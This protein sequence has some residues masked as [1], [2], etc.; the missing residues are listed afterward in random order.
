MLVSKGVGYGMEM[1]SY[2]SWFLDERP[3]GIWYKH[4]ILQA[5]VSSCMCMCLNFFGTKHRH[6]FAPGLKGEAFF[7][8][9]FFFFFFSSSCNYINS[10][11]F[12]ESPFFYFR[13]LLT[14]RS[15]SLT[16]ISLM[17]QGVTLTLFPKF[18][19][20][21]EKMYLGRWLFP[22]ATIFLW[23]LLI[24]IH[25]GWIELASNRFHL[26]HSYMCNWYPTTRL[27]EFVQTRSALSLHE[28]IH[29]NCSVFNYTSYHIPI[30]TILVTI[31]V[32]PI[33]TN[34]F[35]LLVSTWLYD[36]IQLM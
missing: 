29:T 31:I 10:Y 21:D 22:L 25:L 27:Y 20:L 24:I 1:D 13:S 15:V 12:F 28:V 36:F 9:F 3:D 4:E 18:Q 14:L 11:N 7:P 5:S 23:Y 30:D 34:L 2:K 19:Y 8:D 35:N 33:H 26:S 32:G 17:W 6:S 16:L